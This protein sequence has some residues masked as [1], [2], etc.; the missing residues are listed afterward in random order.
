MTRIYLPF[1]DRDAS[2]TS[3][4]NSELLQQF[5][6]IRKTLRIIGGEG[7]AQTPESTMWRHNINALYRYG[8]ATAHCWAV[9]R[10]NNAREFPYSLKEL[11]KL[12]SEAIEKTDFDQFLLE[13]WWM[14][15]PRL[16]ESYRAYYLSK[17]NPKVPR[18]PIWWPQNG[19]AGGRGMAF[20]SYNDVNQDPIG[21]SMLNNAFC[22]NESLHSLREWFGI[23]SARGY[24]MMPPT[25][26]NPFASGFTADERGFAIRNFKAVLTHCIERHEVIVIWTRDLLQLLPDLCDA[27]RSWNVHGVRIVTADSSP[28]DTDASRFA[29]ERAMKKIKK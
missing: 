20:I 7:D 28:V 25:A 9:L 16:H 26:L 8:V 2:L 1:A 6:A 15:D 4:K 5:R 11:R 14:G 21:W 29:I 17:H 22:S 19:V 24:T 18:K 23:E 12:A 13:P 10:N 3:L 27:G